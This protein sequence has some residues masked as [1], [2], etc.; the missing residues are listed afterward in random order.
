MPNDANLVESPVTLFSV[1]ESQNV[2]LFEL[3]NLGGTATL[4]FTSRANVGE[5][6]QDHLDRVKAFIAANAPGA[7]LAFE[8]K[9]I[10][11]RINES[12]GRRGKKK[13]VIKDDVFELK[14]V[15]RTETK[16]VDTK[17]GK[18]WSKLRAIGE[19]DGEQ[20]YAEDFIGSDYIDQNS[21]TQ[22]CGLF[23]N[24]LNWPVDT[25]KPWPDSQPK[26]FVR[27]EKDPKYNNYKVVEFAN[28]APTQAPPPPEN[29]F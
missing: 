15:M 18:H 21:A 27:V 8:F 12:G 2:I 10:T 17:T 23:P 9:D 4:K 26:V 13:I 29:Q 20:I 5:E 24:V 1:D 28:T 16:A 25:E 22:A 3:T 6:L 19:Q 11:A 7:D 14:A